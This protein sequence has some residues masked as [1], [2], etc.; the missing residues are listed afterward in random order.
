LDEK[1]L[2]AYLRERLAN[3]KLPKK[4]HVIDELPKNATGKVLKRVLKEDLKNV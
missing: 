4:L 2:R 1:G 3:Y